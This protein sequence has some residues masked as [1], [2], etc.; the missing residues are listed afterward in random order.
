MLLYISNCQW[1]PKYT[2]ATDLLEDLT[3]VDAM[4]QYFGCQ[5]D[6]RNNH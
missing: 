6:M 5:M 1:I 2:D 3:G 4:E